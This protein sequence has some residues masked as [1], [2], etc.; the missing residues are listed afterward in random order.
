MLVLPERAVRLNESGGE[1]LSLCDGKR[2]ARDIADALRERHPDVPALE[3][4]VHQFL[5]EMRRLGA[6]EHGDAP[7]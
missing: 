5:A 1:I 4:D 2:T 7:A 6:L 3:N